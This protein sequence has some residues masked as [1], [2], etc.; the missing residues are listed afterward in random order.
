LVIMVAIVEPENK[1]ILALPK[2]FQRRKICLLQRF[3][4]ESIPT[5]I[6]VFS[7]KV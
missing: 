1:Q 7:I 6:L 2:K 5:R 4:T 3:I